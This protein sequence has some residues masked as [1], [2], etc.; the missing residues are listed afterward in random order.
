MRRCSKC[1][2]EQAIEEFSLK[3]KKT[4]NRSTLCKGCVREKSRKWYQNPENKKRHLITSRLSAKK[5]RGKKAL[6]FRDFLN[7]VK[8]APCVDCNL[9]YYPW[10]LQ[11]DHTDPSLK[12]FNVAR[13]YIKNKGTI[14][15]EIAK[16]E[17][18]CA[19]CHTMRTFKRKGLING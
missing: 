6:E 9:Q 5:W 8:S 7:Q 18:V 19:N 14:L 11:F 13:M 12:E 17:I 10:Q 2:L 3:N 1:L 16:C 15:K 4:G